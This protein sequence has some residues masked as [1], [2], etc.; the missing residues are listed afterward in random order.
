MNFISWAFLALFIPVLVAR[1]V[2]GRRKTE[3]PFLALVMIVSTIFVIWHVP[4]Y[5]F[6]LLTTI[7][8][9]YLAALLIDREPDGSRR[10]AF[11]LALSLGTNLSLLGFFKYANF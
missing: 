7:G 5:I 2:I 11:Y 4:I 3:P 8:V 6:I 9:D 10:R 1:L